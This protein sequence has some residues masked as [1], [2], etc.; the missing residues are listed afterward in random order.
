[1][2]SRLLPEF[3]AVA[4]PTRRRPQQKMENCMNKI[5]AALALAG[6]LA[7]PM[8]S[9]AEDS[10]LYVNGSVGQARFGQ[11]YYGRHHMGYDANLG[12]RWSVAPAFQVGVEAGYV[13]LGN[14]GV[15]SVYPGVALPDATLHGW[16]LGGTAKYD[17]TSNWYV[18]GRAG[19]LRWSGRT[20]EPIGGVPVAYSGNGT[21]WYTGAGFG[22]N[23]NSNWSLGWNYNY[24]HASKSGFPLSGSLTSISA[25][26]RFGAM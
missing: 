13:N 15:R 1:M 3:A 19:L 17:I 9:H 8:V 21:G 5:F 2:F 24:Y 18:S 20:A 26:Y 25:E 14:Y 12:Y 16:T 10:G 6:V 23:F 7:L 11:S 22:Y 4:I